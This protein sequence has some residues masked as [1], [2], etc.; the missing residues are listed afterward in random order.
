MKCPNCSGTLY[1]DI[2]S[3][4]LK[5]HS[6][7]SVFDVDKYEGNNDAAED[8]ISGVRL[9]TCRNCGAELISANDEAVSYCSYCGSEAILEGNLE[10]V[11][12][13]KY[14]IPFRVTKAECKEIYKKALEHKMYVPKEFK[15]PEFIDRFRPFYIPYWMYQIRFRDDSFDLKGY[16]NYT[17]GGY[18]YH[19]EYE[20]TASVDDEGIYGFPFDA[21]R[22]F[23]DSIAEKIA[24]F[25]RRDLT[26]YRPGYLAGMYAD[27]PNVEAETYKSEVIEK[28]SD[29]VVKNIEQRFGNITLK[30]PKKKKL[31]EFLQT[32]YAG[33]DTMFLPVWFL[34]WKKNDRVAYAVVNGQTGQIHID[35]PA[36]INQFIFYTLA[37]AAI[38]FILFTLFV[39]VTSRFVIWF[40]ALLVYLVSIRYHKELK[41]IRDRENHVFDKGYLLTDEDEL[42]MSEKKRDRLRRKGKGLFAGAAST[43]TIIT[44]VLFVFATSFAMLGEIYDALVSQT[45]AIAITFLVG[46][47]EVIRFVK[48]LAVTRYL[49]NRRSFFFSILAMGAVGYSF[50][51]AVSEPVQDWWY[52]L[53]A[54]I[55]L[56][57]ATFM[58][59]DLIA[60]YNESS[61]RP[62]PSFYTRKGGNDRVKDY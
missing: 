56:A 53:G 30:F 26:E 38:L 59:V 46:V 17:L 60:R 14:I 34:T 2:K 42:K 20:V 1:F 8:V 16:K 29:E 47:L 9:F 50:F 28:A 58:A 6:C 37:G 11:K 35:L 51:V 19:D 5:C 54:L 32:T 15:D 3:R 61:T 39:S 36:D 43:V 27:S 21:S 55:C 7:D 49:K 18:D 13:P 44:I 10:G 33:E 22:N 62:L 25:N 4:K 52:Y 23:D 57:A 24:P 12:R 48:L 45:G 41:E 31:Q 40:S